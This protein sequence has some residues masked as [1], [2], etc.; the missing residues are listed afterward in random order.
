M[1]RDY[2]A[3]LDVFELARVAFEAIKLRAQQQE[4][5]AHGGLVLA[6]GGFGD[7]SGAVRNGSSCNALRRLADDGG[8]GGDQI[9]LAG[10]KGALE[11]IHPLRRQLEKEVDDVADERR[12]AFAHFVAYPRIDGFGNSG[13]GGTGGASHF[14]GPKIGFQK[15]E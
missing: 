14:T 12:I 8:F 11:F 1:G 10:G 9:A 15:T 4:R 6:A 5:M 7:A 13:G 2:A 3:G